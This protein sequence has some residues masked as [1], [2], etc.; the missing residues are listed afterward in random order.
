MPKVTKINGYKGFDKD[1]KC[2]DKQYAVGETYTHKGKIK[3]CESG[4]HFVENPLDLFDYYPPSEAHYAEVEASGV[5]RETEYDSKRVARSLTVGAELSLHSLVD[6]GVKFILSKVDFK[7]AKESNTGYQSAATN[8]G[9]WSAA[10]NTGNQSAA[11][12]EGKDSIAIVTGYQSSA[13]G[14]KG[15]WLVLTERE[16]YAKRYKIKEVRAVKV[17]GK[18]IKADTLYT[19]KDGKVVES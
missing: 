6:L 17:D 8:T 13:S 3:L 14:K 16:D 7:N 1:W 9:N 19:L 4:L 10:T 12:V 15:C 2:R 5:S 18:L 11:T